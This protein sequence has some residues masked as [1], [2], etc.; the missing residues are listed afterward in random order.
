MD[1]MMKNA[2]KIIVYSLLGI[3]LNGI[4]AAVVQAAPGKPEDRQQQEQRQ[5]PR[6]SK[7]YSSQ[8]DKKQQDKHYEDRKR[9][10][11]KREEWQHKDQS[12]VPSVKLWQC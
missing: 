4:G 2:Q 8:P 11:K 10:E 7:S 12:D 5:E 9:D 6:Q 3:L 1:T